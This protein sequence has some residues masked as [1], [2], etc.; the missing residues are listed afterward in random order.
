[1][2]G[3]RESLPNIS[4]S[5]PAAGRIFEAPAGYGYDSWNTPDKTV[6]ALKAG[7]LDSTSTG[8]AGTSSGYYSWR[9][10]VFDASKSNSI[11]GK[12]YHIN[13]TSMAVKS[14]LRNA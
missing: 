7:G 14:W 9:G 13:P 2:I 10:I 5:L 1:L 11:Y 4:G 3:Q 12:G 8:I 6:G